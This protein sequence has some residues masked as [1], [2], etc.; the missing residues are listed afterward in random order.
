VVT[1]ILLGFGAAIAQS[2]SY[3]FSRIFSDKYPRSTLIL[4]SLSHCIMGIFS[5]I[6]FILLCPATLPKFSE[7]AP[8]LFACALFYLAGQA[9]LFLALTRTD[10]SRVSPL[11]GLKLLF[12]TGISVAFLQQHFLPTQWAAV[13]ICV[14]AAVM[15]NWSGGRIAWQSLALIIF[16]CLVY[17]I[18][19]LNIKLLVGHFLKLGLFKSSV[20]SVC[21]CYMVCGL[22]G[23][24]MLVFL[25]RTLKS[26]WINA[27]PFAIAWLCAMFF[28]FA[29]FASIGVVFGNI[30][31]STRGVISIVLGSFIA[32][33]GL[34]HLEKKITTK[35]LLRRIFA[36]VLMVLSIALFYAY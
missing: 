2:L 35:V 11:L 30:V 5:V 26:Q 36:A 28:L 15:L 21:L 22:A 7:Y 23:M 33:V 8:S 17:S 25:P 29:C 27:V 31:Q 10:A 1:G 6:P 4:L 34:E 32:G 16:A 9:C 18:S 3:V 19:D 24:I 12:L 20:L 14:I 13:F